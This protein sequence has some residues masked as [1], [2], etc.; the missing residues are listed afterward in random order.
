MASFSRQIL[1]QCIPY[2]YER[3]PFSQTV[4]VST[5]GGSAPI[6][7]Q[8]SGW[9]PSPSPSTLVTLEDVATVRDPNLQIQYQA[10]GQTA[11]LYTEHHRPDLEPIPVRAQAIQSLSLQALNTTS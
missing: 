8:I 6:I 10:D 2:W 4:A 3:L 5:V 9:N 1:Q 11:T 7:G